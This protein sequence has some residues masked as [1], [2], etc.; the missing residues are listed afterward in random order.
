MSRFTARVGKSID[1]VR[2]FDE[3]AVKALEGIA[4]R[5]RNRPALPGQ[6]ISAISPFAAFDLAKNA[7]STEEQVKHLLITTATRISDRVKPLIDDSFNLAHKLDI[8]QATLD[9]IKE[10]ATGEIGG[11][12]RT[13]VL[14]A[15]WTRLARADDYEQYGSHTSLLTEMTGFYEISSDV[16]KETII[17]LNRVEAELRDLRNDYASPGLI[18]KENPLEVIITLLR[19]SGQRLEAGKRKLEHI[20]KGERPQRND[21]PNESTTTVT[22]T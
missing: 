3:H 10:L 11:L 17:A 6:I 18:L 16:V 9:R 15:L 5:Q 14:G 21:I 4:E 12:P 19:T 13:E 20:E 1:T 2:T 22:A 7:D 8:I